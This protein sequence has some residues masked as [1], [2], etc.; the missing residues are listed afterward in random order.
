MTRATPCAKPGAKA[1]KGQPASSKPPT[2][3]RAGRAAG[4]AP[5]KKAQTG[6]PAPGAPPRESPEDP[7]KAAAGASA[8]WGSDRGQQVGQLLSR[9]LDLAEAGLTLGVSLMN[10]VGAAAQQQILERFMSGAAAVV[11]AGMAQAQAPA[12]EPPPPP[13]EPAGPEPGAFGITNLLPLLPGTPVKVGFSINNDS[14]DSPKKLTLSLEGFIGEAH[15]HSL[16]AALSLKP[17]RK[18]IAPMDFEKF[19]L[20]GTVPAATPPDVYRGWIIVSSDTEMRIPAW[21]SVSS[22]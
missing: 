20:E 16:E 21:L 9:S 5:P 7:P 1:P 10:K 18:T 17:A 14:M 2:K 3:T 12:P 4:E 6:R 11:E 15:G 22:L 13:A 19:V 8:G